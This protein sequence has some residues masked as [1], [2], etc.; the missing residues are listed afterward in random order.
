MQ[1]VLNTAAAVRIDGLSIVDG[2]V[3]VI[4]DNATKEDNKEEDLNRT[5]DIV[6][7]GQ[8]I[9]KN[10]KNLAKLSKLLNNAK[11]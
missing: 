9:E 1:L 7:I 10:F 11:Y 3:Q 6:Y 2:C 5:E 8:P 4:K